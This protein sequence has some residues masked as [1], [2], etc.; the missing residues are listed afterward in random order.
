M[1]VAASVLPH[2]PLLVPE[3]SVATPDWLAELRAAVAASVEATLGSSPD[4]VVAVGSAA[5]AGEWDETAGGSMAP[6]GV[7]VRAGGPETALPLSLAVAARVLDAAGWSGPRRYAALAADAGAEGHA[8][9]GERLAASAERVA[10]L[11]M[12]DGSAKR[13]SEAPGY[14]DDRAADFDTSVVGAL[15][16]ADLP[17]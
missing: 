10:M 17:T 6:Y 7:D 2:P 11:V 8:A 9:A 12:G 13:T 14:L 4:L 1:L 15:T 3:V 16:T 5:Q